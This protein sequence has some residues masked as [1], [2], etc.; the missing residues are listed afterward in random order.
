MIAIRYQGRETWEDVVGLVGKG[1]R[2][3]PVA[4]R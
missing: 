3:I 1:L 2:L 4:C